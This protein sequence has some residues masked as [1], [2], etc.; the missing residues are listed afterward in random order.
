VTESRSLRK[1]DKLLRPVLANAGIEAQYRRKLEAM[2]DEMARS[3]FWWIK[4][5]YRRDPPEMANDELSSAAMRDAI[6]KLVKRW[7]DHF[8]DASQE[9]AKY[10]ALSVSQRSDAALRKI[11]KD[12]GFA[13]EFKMTRAQRDVLNASIAENV[14]LIKSIPAQFLT[15]VEGSVYRA[16]SAGRDLKMLT[17]DL[18][19]HYGVTRRRAEFIAR[20]QSNKV[21]ASLN[22]A[23][24]I[25]IGVDQA[26]WRHSN[27]GKTQRPTHVAKDGKKYDV[28]KGMY[29]SA[30]KK[31]VLPG[32]LPNCRCFS[33]AVIPGFN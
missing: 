19:K 8:D 5:A 14:S 26:V 32:E 24:M 20:D 11:L 27:A 2:I 29:D 1:T 33:R 18:Q 22:R 21:T 3:V 31:F 10:F 30:V 23:R 6:K 25:E 9:L 13:I 17:D 28:A 7:Q 12:G 15:Q 16:V 4:A